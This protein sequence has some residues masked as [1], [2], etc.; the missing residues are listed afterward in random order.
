MN[1]MSAALVFTS[2]GIPFLLSGE[3]FARTKVNADGTLNENSYNSSDAVNNIGWSRKKDYAD[4]YE[5]YRGLIQLR[6]NH[7]AFRMDTTEE[8]QK[9]IKFIDVK[10]KN[11]VAY[12]LTN[13]GIESENWKSMIVAFNANNEAVDV[14]I[15]SNDYV[16]V[17]NGEKAGTTSLGTVSGDKLTLPAKSSYVL[18][19]KAS[20]EKVADD[21]KDPEIIDPNGDASKNN[22]DSKITN[23]DKTASNKKTGDSTNMILVVALVSLAVAASGTLVVVNNKKKKAIRK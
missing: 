19:D 17:V 2:Q 20:F 15:P 18:V 22:D 1:K 14:T 12:S 7:K 4:L 11:V 21:P 9:N 5:Y 13:E 3:E 16:V 8:I 6:A 23:S 10:D